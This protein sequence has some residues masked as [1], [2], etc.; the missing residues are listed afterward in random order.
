MTALR[1]SLMKYDGQTIIV[2][3]YIERYGKNT[4]TYLLTNL[5]D[6]KTGDEL[7]DHIWIEIGKWADGFRPGDTI[8]LQAVV[9]SYLKGHLGFNPPINAP[10]PQIDWTLDNPINAKILSF[11]SISRLMPDGKIY[12]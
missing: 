5:V 7:T 3:C 9:I 8:E 12:P 4:C 1:K 10:I 6:V 11:G 2:R